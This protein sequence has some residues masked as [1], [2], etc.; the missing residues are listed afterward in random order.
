MPRKR[1]LDLRH[2]L[3]HDRVAVRAVVRRVHRVRVVVERRRV[4]DLDEQHPR[5]AL[6][7]PVLVELPP[8]LLLDA[9]VAREREA[10][11]VV[12]RE[13]RVGRRLAPVADARREVAVIDDERVPRFRMSVETLRQQDPRAEEHVASPELREQLAPDAEVLHVFRFFCLEVR[14]WPGFPGRARVADLS[15]TMDRR[16][17]SPHANRD[18]PAC[19]RTAALPTGQAGA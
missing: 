14:D 16:P 11:A 10:F 15:M 19:W 2:Q 9:V 8:V 1:L 3:L 17:C 4:L 5:K 18:S 12:R 6:A 7:G 13:V